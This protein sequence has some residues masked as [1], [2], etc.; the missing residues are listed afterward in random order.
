MSFKIFSSS[1]VRL[2]EIE[3]M[4][5]GSNIPWQESQMCSQWPEW[6]QGDGALLSS[7]PHGKVGRGL[8]QAQEDCSRPL[9]HQTSRGVSWRATSLSD[10]HFLV[11]RMGEISL[12]IWH[13]L[14]SYIVQWP[15]VVTWHQLALLIYLFWRCIFPQHSVWFN[16][17]GFSL[18]SCW[19]PKPRDAMRVDSRQR[20]KLSMPQC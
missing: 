16:Q 3:Q 6:P 7:A 18:Q 13:S 20:G 15:Q 8:K 4:F 9:I 1:S 17:L 5:K 19:F 14:L 10:L 2:K 12:K 11:H